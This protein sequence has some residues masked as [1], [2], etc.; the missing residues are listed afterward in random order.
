ME[1]ISVHKFQILPLLEK[2]D[3]FV[4]QLGCL[5]WCLAWYSNRAMFFLE[6]VVKGQYL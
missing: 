5:R 3:D 6:K 4:S 2:I 1:V